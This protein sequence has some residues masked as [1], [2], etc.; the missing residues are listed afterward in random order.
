M[1]SKQRIAYDPVANVPAFVSEERT[2]FPQTNVYNNDLI[3]VKL[4]KVSPPAP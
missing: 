2:H 3:E 1:K 4:I